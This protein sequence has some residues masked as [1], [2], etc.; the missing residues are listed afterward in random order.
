MA[1]TLTQQPAEYAPVYNG[2]HFMLTS[3]NSAAENFTIQMRVY[4]GATLLA[5]INYPYLPTSNVHADAG[6]IFESVVAPDFI[7]TEGWQQSD[8][9]AKYTIEFQERF[10]S[11]PEVSGSTTTVE[12]FAFNGALRYF[13][14]NAYDQS[15]YLIDISSTLQNFLTYMPSEVLVRENQSIE[16]GMFTN[17]DSG[18]NPVFRAVIKT[19]D[20]QGNLQQTAYVENTFTDYAGTDADRF[21]SF[22]CGPNDINDIALTSGTQPLLTDGIYKYTV[23]IEDDDGPNPSS[24][25]QTFIMDRSC[26]RY[27][28]PV[29]LYFLN[30][31]G[32]FDSFSFSLANQRA[33][34]WT[35]SSFRK[36]AGQITGNAFAFNANGEQQV[37]FDTQEQERWRLVSEY[38]TEDMALWL[39]DLVGSPKVYMTHPDY[40]SVFAEVIIDTNSLTVQQTAIERVF[41]AEMNIKLSSLNFRQRL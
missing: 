30:P 14:Y 38:I 31:L 4:E 20:Y 40:P 1:L 27:N 15:Q 34:D 26:S 23:Q 6:R 41:N 19:Y 28:Q 17:T 24:I 21:L 2:L 10:G 25:L 29:V 3:T 36:Y 33:Y 39:R 37:N 16:L 22:V 5:T 7:T 11:T 8:S 9:W 13:D 35:K 32:R 12:Q 18:F